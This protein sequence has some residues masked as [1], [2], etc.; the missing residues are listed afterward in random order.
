MCTFLP[1]SHLQ[2]TVSLPPVYTI[3]FNKSKQK[4]DLTS[5]MYGKKSYLLS[6]NSL[7]SV[8]TG[9]KPSFKTEYSSVPL[10]A[11]IVWTPT[12]MN[13]GNLILCFVNMC[14]LL[15]LESFDCKD[16]KEKDRRTNDDVR[17]K[18]APS[19]PILTLTGQEL[20]LFLYHQPTQ[21]LLNLKFVVKTTILIVTS[22]EIA[23]T[24]HFPRGL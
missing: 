12:C 4:A 13:D 1:Y 14:Y 21:M 16:G 10:R 18:G 19:P 6:I 3:N 11:A 23:S 9:A 22:A 20:L 7:I 15:W 2:N 17:V 24:M 5:R 8:I